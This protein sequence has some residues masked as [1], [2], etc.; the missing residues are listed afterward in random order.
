MP[1]KNVL[2]ILVSLSLDVLI[3]KVLRIK[4]SV[5]QLVLVCHFK[6]NE[7]FGNQ[8]NNSFT[9]KTLIIKIITRLS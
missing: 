4:K 8:N 1:E 2:I 6:C 7:A 3:E 5:L 9:G